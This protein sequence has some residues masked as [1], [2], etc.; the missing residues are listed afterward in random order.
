MI[1]D[2]NK[3]ILCGGKGRCCPIVEN[4]GE[5]FTISDDYNGKV[6]LTPEE[7]KML[8]DA[9]AHFQITINNK[10]EKINS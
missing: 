3:I 5:N 8:G 1:I 9:I 10:N 2:N 7:L 6:T 4:T